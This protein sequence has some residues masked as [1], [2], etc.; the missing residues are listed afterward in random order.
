[1]KFERGH[2]KRPK[3]PSRDWEGPVTTVLEEYV[4][5]CAYPPLGSVRLSNDGDSKPRVSPFKMAE[6]KCDCERAF[7]HALRNHPH[8]ILALQNI[9]KELANLP[10]ESVTAG[11]RVATVQLLGPVLS[12]CG[13]MPWTYFTR[14]RP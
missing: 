12:Q 4:I 14:V 3:E 2:K 13:L 11:E 8:L 5:A 7:A 1:M 9:L 10:S 6:F